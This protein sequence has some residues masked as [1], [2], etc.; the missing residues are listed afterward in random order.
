[1]RAVNLLPH[2]AYAA[3]QRL[4]YAPVVL[5]A[6]TPLLASALVFLG[7]SNEHA[8]VND[9][10]IALDVVQS[11]VSALK[12]SQALTAQASVVSAERQKR[13]LELSDAL[14]KQV[15]WDVA[16]E[17]IGRVLPANAWLTSLTAQSPA[18]VVVGTSSTT[19]CTITGYTSTQ[20]DVA[21]VLARLALVPAL[22]NVALGSTSTSSIG[23]KTVVQFTIT[24]SIAGG[25]A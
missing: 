3:K 2:D 8:K 20:A 16:F 7:Y 10:R 12:P 11:Q 24:A 13:Q 9:Q 18:P 1:M 15:P 14:A 21:Q 5:A 22:T 19:S 25:A 17:Q 23:S 6:T 4:P